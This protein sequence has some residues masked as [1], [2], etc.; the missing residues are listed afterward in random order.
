VS[1]SNIARYAAIAG[2]LA[3]PLALVVPAASATTGGTGSAYGIAAAGPLVNLPPTPSVQAPGRNSGARLPANPLIHLRLLDVAAKPGHARASV[4]DLRVVKSA[5]TA[6]LIVARCYNGRGSSD[7]ARVSLA[8]RRLKA[9]ASPN[10][11]ISILVRGLGTV[12]VTLNKQVRTAGGGLTVT[13]LEISLPLGPGR[14]QVVDVSS[15]S[16]SAGSGTPST[17]PPTATPAPSPTSS[18]PGEAPKPTPVPSNLP[19]T[20]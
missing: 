7:L 9:H 13:A 18:A 11:R 8:G 14:Q 10:T 6:H 1:L 16:C 19:V 12:A 3:A 5:L 17:P 4:A 2:A 15:A 20:G